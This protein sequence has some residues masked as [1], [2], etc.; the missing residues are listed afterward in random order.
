M[1]GPHRRSSEPGTNHHPRPG[2]PVLRVEHGYEVVNGDHI[3]TT[4]RKRLG[5]VGTV[6][7][8]N[9]R[10]SQAQRCFPL[11]GHCSQRGSCRQES[12]RRGQGA[13]YL[14]RHRQ[15]PLVEQQQLVLSRGAEQCLYQ[16]TCCSANPWVATLGHS[17]VNCYACRDQPLHQNVPMMVACAAIARYVSIRLLISPLTLE[18][19]F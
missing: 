12:M 6:I 13:S 2:G 1:C 8:L 19:K 18:C 5:V 10:P 9:A 15:A 17:Y 11:I 16:T 7:Q 3:R 14:Y 4:R